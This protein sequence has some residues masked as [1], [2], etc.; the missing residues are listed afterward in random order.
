MRSPRGI[1]VISPWASFSPPTER[2]TG[3]ACETPSVNFTPIGSAK[4]GADAAN[5]R[6]NVRMARAFMGWCLLNPSSRA[7]FRGTDSKARA[8]NLEG[9]RLLHGRGFSMGPPPHELL[10]EWD[11]L[12]AA[13]A[14]LWTVSG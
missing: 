8:E 6:T 13:G 9:A 10:V 4:T 3:K 1:C 7:G 14:L 11:A 5:V 2:R 12:S